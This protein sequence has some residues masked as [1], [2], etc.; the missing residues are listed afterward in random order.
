MIQKSLAEQP[1]PIY[2]DGLNVRDW[3]HVEDHCSAI[4][5][6]IKGGQTG[7]VYN[8]GGDAEMTNIDVVRTICSQLD[9]KY[10]RG[11]GSYFDLVTYVTDRP[12]HDRRY[13]IDS[14]KLQGELGWRPE[15]T[16]TTGIEQTVQWYL[17][18]ESWWRAL[19][20]REGVGKRLGV[21]V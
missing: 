16:F 14:S 17:D 8:V 18:N 21:T 3:L 20:N 12:G 9:S 7:E 10:P 4:R 11:G 6:V 5:A 15:H 19:Q 13:A 2:G 1:L